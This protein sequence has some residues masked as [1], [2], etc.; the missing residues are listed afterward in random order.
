M[1][2]RGGC[3]EPSAEGASLSHRHG[4][5]GLDAAGGLPFR[6]R[7][8]SIIAV[9]TCALDRDGGIVLFAADAALLVHDEKDAVFAYKNRNIARNISIRS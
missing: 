9:S 5:P 4:Q 1:A 6:L 8:G 7:P 3:P 2:E